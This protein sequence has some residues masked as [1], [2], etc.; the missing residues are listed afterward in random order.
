MQ[1]KFSGIPFLS[2]SLSEATVQLLSHAKTKQGVSYHLVNAY[3][4]VSASKNPAYQNLLESSKTNL[5]DGFP[6]SLLTQFSRSPITQIRGMDF[7][8]EILGMCEAENLSIFFW[9]STDQVL[10]AIRQR[11]ESEFPKLQIAGMYS[12]PFGDSPSEQDRDS[13]GLIQSSGASLVLVALGTPKQDLE[14][15]RIAVST[16][17]TTLAIGAAF[18]FYAGTKPEAPRWVAKL[19]FEWLFRL[20]TEPR[21]LWKRYVFGNVQFLVQVLKKRAPK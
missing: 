5:A 16:G 11:A 8:M 6:I 2:V 13:L 12:P 18:D 3:S 7:F 4:I 19:G 15:H 21:R 20:V 1:R 17:A 9:G 14:A 10:N